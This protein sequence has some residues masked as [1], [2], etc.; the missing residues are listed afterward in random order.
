MTTLHSFVSTSLHSF[1]GMVVFTF[2]GTFSQDLDRSPMHTLTFF[3]LHSVLFTL[4]QV[5]FGFE[6]TPGMIFPLL[7]LLFLLLLLLLL[8]FLLHRGSV[9]PLSHSPVQQKQ[10]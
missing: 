1:T 9:L 3:L 2:F 4:R 8:L 5:N 6:L 10:Q 7:L